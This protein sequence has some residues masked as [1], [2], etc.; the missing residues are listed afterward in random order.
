MSKAKMKQ[1]SSCG[2]E[3]AASAKVCPKCGAKNKK[4]I[5]KRAWFIILMVVIVI[6][7]IG[8][9]GG[10]EKKSETK[11]SSES[12][13]SEEAETITYT[14]YDVS[15][16]MADLNANAMNASETYKD[17]YVAVTGKLSNIDSNGSYINVL[18]SDDEFAIIGV[19]C[20]IKDDSQKELLSS[21]KVGDTITVSGKI[22]DVGEV[23][24]YSLDID[25]IN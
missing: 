9:I 18:P 1:C 11:T 23:L 22:T 24:G 17:Q 5:Y 14:P 15:Q 12:T 8:S 4:P 6:G 2:T 19:Q 10:G 16:M 3:I 7:V 25:S 20:Y 21:L 13:K